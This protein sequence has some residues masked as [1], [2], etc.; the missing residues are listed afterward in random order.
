MHHP[1][2]IKPEPREFPQVFG[3]T[4]CLLLVSHFNQLFGL[5]N[6]SKIAGGT[7]T[8]WEIW[9]HGYRKWCFAKASILFYFVDSINSSFWNISIILFLWVSTVSW[10]FET[11]LSLSTANFPPL[12]RSKLLSSSIYL[13]LELKKGVP[14]DHAR[15]TRGCFAPV[16]FSSWRLWGKK[17]EWCLSK[18]TKLECVLK[19]NI[20]SNSASFIQR[21]IHSPM[22][23]RGIHRTPMDSISRNESCF[24]MIPKVGSWSNYSHFVG[25]TRHADPQILVTYCPTTSYLHHH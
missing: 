25:G 4:A 20:L 18:P 13:Q 6:I 9:G 3:W 19:M 24:S 7:C 21:G 14:L 17:N 11:S 5:N 16:R 2:S 22:D 1:P 8:P 15:V 23:S 10:P 12:L